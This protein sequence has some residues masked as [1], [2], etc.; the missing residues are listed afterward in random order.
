[1]KGSAR[2]SLK[3]ASGY[4]WAVVAAA[5]LS[6]AAYKTF[7]H[8]HLDLPVGC[9]EFGYL[10][11]ARG[12]SQGNP[13]VSPT[14][15]PFDPGL[16]EA[17]KES[18][19]PVKAYMHVICPHAYHLDPGRFKIINQYPPGTP[20]LLSLLPRDSAKALAPPV[21][22]VFILLTLLLAFGLAEGRLT[23]FE[24]GL[25]VVVTAM[26][27][28]LNPFR[29]SFFQVNS[30]TPTFGLL[31]GAGFLLNRKPHLSLL[32]LSLTT[33]FRIVNV[34]LLAP[35]LIMYLWHRKP[36]RVFS[37]DMVLR[38]VKGASL[39][40]AG[41]LWIYI[42]YAWILLGNP[43]RSTYSFL[44]QALTLSGAPANAA[45]YFSFRQ[46]WF[47]WQVALLVLIAILSWIWKWPRR[48]VV[49]SAALIAVNSIFFVFHKVRIDYY[50]YAAVLI[51][52]GLALWPA[53]QKIKETRFVRLVPAA[54]LVVLLAAVVFLARGFP[55]QDYRRLFHEQTQAYADGFS[56]YD[57]VWAELRSG[58][59]EYATGKAGFRYM[60]GSDRMRKAVMDWLRA[61]HY[62]QALW[63]SDLTLSRESLEQTLTRFRLD[64]SV[65]QCPG[66]GT[67]IEINP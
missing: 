47:V 66:L 16:I 67:I 53:A 3:R 63:V 25:A 17:L 9:D 65:K 55:R 60:W 44:D 5:I 48:W 27:L 23:V 1:M 52:F 10:Y 49:F 37:K 57:V 41:G 39:C 28:A 40:V 26:L 4:L 32:L 29:S 45:F 8:R 38:A 2:L 12:I 15:R 64:Y 36:D 43:L 18:T 61:H 62:R 34:L 21:F 56:S 22:A 24:V 31:I 50:P 20:L 58:T 19:F 11:L 51:L 30:I 42:A 13:F 7:V 35:F 6:L 46:P 59:L 54:G 14:A 33:V